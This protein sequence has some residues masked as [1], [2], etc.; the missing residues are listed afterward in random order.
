MDKEFHTVCMLLF[1]V[2]ARACFMVN[3]LTTAY[4][5][6]TAAR[7]ITP[8]V[9]YNLH[10]LPIKFHIPRNI[11]LL[12]FKALY[13]LAPTCIQNLTVLLMHSG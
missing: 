8:L 3:P 9:L 4:F 12:T 1:V 7:P 13:G 5:Q 6:D 10:W 2:I 11:L